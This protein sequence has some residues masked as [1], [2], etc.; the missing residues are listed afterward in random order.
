MRYFT[1]D[2][3]EVKP[4]AERK[5]K[6]SVANN[7]RPDSPS[8]PLSEQ[9]LSDIESIIFRLRSARRAGASRMLVFGAHS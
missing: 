2:A 5:N 7:V 6:L 9:A 8:P 4:L 3:L 1:R